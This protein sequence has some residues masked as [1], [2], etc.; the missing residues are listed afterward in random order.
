MTNRIRAYL[1]FIFLFSTLSKD[2]NCVYADITAVIIKSQN[3]SAYNEVIEGF[4][5]ECD[6]NNISVG[7]I[8]D[9]KGKM[10]PGLSTV[11]KIGKEE[12]DIIL[13]IGV[14]ATTIAKEEIK[15]IPI[16]F[17]MVINHERFKLAGQNITGISTE[18]TAAKQM[19]GFR[20]L[21]EPLHNI[22]VIYDSSKTS[23]IIERAEKE[24]ASVGVGLIKYEIRSPKMISEAL[25]SLISKIDALWVLPD[26][27]VVTK[28]SFELIKNTTL[29][30][31]IP[32]LCTSDAFVKAGALAAVYS[33]YK[34]TGRQA[35]YMAA[36]LISAPQAGSS[37]IVSPDKYKLAVNSKTAELLGLS[38]E[39]ESIMKKQNVVVYP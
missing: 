37:G 1:F 23:N 17:C 24:M 33:D 35:A 28:E 27:T 15:D 30:N 22:G 36:K 11:Q 8:Y 14:L 12:P 31:N 2:I 5:S 18:I 29:N 3:L 39:T 25:D 16:I 19:E 20:M 38:I 6:K 32:L 7:S 10:K 13:T 4:E 34:D 26:S 21:L 9:L